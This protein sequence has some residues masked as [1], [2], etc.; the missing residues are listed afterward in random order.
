MEFFHKNKYNGKH[1][2]SPER[3]YSM[4]L[5]TNGRFITMERQGQW[6]KNMLVSGNKIVALGNDEIFSQVPSDVKEHDLKERPVLPGFYDSHMHFISTC[7]N[8]I[9]IN[10][11]TARSID[12]V[13]E[14][15]D[16]S[17]D[18]Y[19]YPVRLGKRMSEFHLKERRFPT[20]KELDLVSKDFPLVISSIEFHTVLMNSYA[21]NLFKIPFTSDGYEKDEHNNF[22]GRLCN[23]SASIA[24]R[25]V[26][27]L[28]NEKMHLK[29]KK[30]VIEMALSHGVTTMVS[31]EGGPLFHKKHPKILLKNK[32]K[33]PIDVEM[34]YSTTDLKEIMRHGLPRVG[35][36][37]FLDGS[38]RSHNAAL[39]SSYKDSKN[40][41]GKL[42][43]TEKELEEF[44]GQAHD[45]DLQ[46]AVHAVGPRAIDFL[47]KAYDKVLSKKPYRDHRHRIEHFELPFSRH[48]NHA[49]KLGL[50]LAMHPAY[51]IFF[52]EKGMMYDTRLGKER[53]MLTNPLREIIEE[54]ICVAGCSDSD[55]MP[56]DP[57]IGIH[58]AV[59][60]PNPDSRI[61]PY[62]AI[63]MF[64]ING[65]YSIFQENEK[66]SLV[67]GKRADFIVLDS[68]PFTVEREKIKNI[69][70]LQT[71]K[72]GKLVY[73][74]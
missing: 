6:Y 3:G 66:G 48:I 70:V 17:L 22:T 2:E 53:S 28:L 63:E 14:L 54:G 11:E 64:T 60:H 25:K 13:L 74:R 65:A 31:V 68:S 37:L 59:N 1:K 44:I 30:K 10:F 43:F 52:R 67:S 73:E 12:D 36:D 16:V 50:V 4:T 72:D 46:V 71:Y 24:L 62:Q 39:F 26:Y 57:L 21:M 8:E 51:E 27:A 55:V 32:S 40:N 56:L 15:I 49:K 23:K 34:F 69:Q 19:K 47:L 20:R 35:G 9:A 58:A 29:G 5:F 45:L 18:N 61:T 33:F 38:F 42:F 41:L 7:L